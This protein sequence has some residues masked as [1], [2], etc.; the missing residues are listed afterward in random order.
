MQ[1]G[2]LLIGSM[3]GAVAAAALVLSGHSILLALAAYSVVGAL[4]CVVAV[5]LG[6]VLS[7]VFGLQKDLLAEG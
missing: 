5:V 4:G 3:V 7:R 2:L 1:V 6:C